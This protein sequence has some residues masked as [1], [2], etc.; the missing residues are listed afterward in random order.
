MARV[1][2]LHEDDETQV[3]GD[4]AGAGGG[5]VT[6]GIPGVPQV[7]AGGGGAAPPPQRP[8]KFQD[9]S[10]LLYANQG[11]GKQNAQ[12][13]IGVADQRAGLAQRQLQNAQGAY[14][15]QAA[16]ATQPQ[17]VQ[18]Q[19][20]TV[21]RPGLLPGQRTTTQINAAPPDYAALQRQASATYGGPRNL[22]E[23][24]GVDQGRLSGA[25]TEAS[26]AANLLGAPA[27][28]S[29][30]LG[31][32]GGVGAFDDLLAQRE[33]GA[34]LRAAKQRLGGIR[35]QLAAAVK[36]TSVSDR[37]RSATEA[38]AAQAQGLLDERDAAE[39]ARLAAENADAQFN[40]TQEDEDLY[41]QFAQ[42]F[43]ALSP[44]LARDRGPND[45]AAPIPTGFQDDEAVR[46]YFD[47]NKDRIRELLGSR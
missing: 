20:P 26:R 40:A 13:A 24:T 44:V 10:R 35:D 33:G 16:G 7:G 15:T 18:A 38:S 2:T 5:A 29:T 36:D 25:F 1:A 46:A 47:E 41:E 19:V 37:A 31:R 45:R 32:T 30:L 23:A 17:V 6:Q 12:A 43:A 34:E 8:G 4:P 39:A 9:I 3:A 28:V 27:G 22:N 11:Q 14:R 21:Q 42:N